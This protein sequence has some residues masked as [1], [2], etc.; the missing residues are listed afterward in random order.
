[1]IDNQNHSFSKT[2]ICK[3]IYC[4][5][6]LWI[7]LVER[8]QQ[9]VQ[10]KLVEHTK[11]LAQSTGKMQQPFWHVTALV[12]VSYGLSDRS[13][14]AGGR[15]W[16]SVAVRR[17][18]VQLRRCQGEGAC[19]AAGETCSASERAH[20]RAG[21]ATSTDTYVRQPQTGRS[22]PH[23]CEGVVFLCGVRLGLWLCVV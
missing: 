13:M 3:S 10:D 21:A 16:R 18:Y 17:P 23:Y 5:V 9:R 20:L 12:H 19:R 4:P 15:W 14:P 1:M 2:S 22:I 6:A 8:R 7:G 11:T